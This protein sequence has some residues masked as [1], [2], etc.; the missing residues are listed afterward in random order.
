MNI[1]NLVKYS[2]EANQLLIT[3]RSGW[4]FIGK[5]R[6]ETVAYHSFYTAVLAHW[7]SLEE[8]KQYPHIDPH[9]TLLIPL[10]HDLHEVRTGDPNS[11]Y[12]TYFPRHK[13]SEARASRDQI[14]RTEPDTKVKLLRYHFDFESH[15]TLAGKIAK[16]ADWLQ[17]IFMAK[18]FLDEDFPLAQRWIDGTREKLR[19]KTAQDIAAKI[20]NTDNV[21]LETI[22]PRLNA[23]ECF[24]TGVLAFVLTDP[25]TN[26]PEES[27][28]CA[29]IPFIRLVA[30]ITALSI[31]LKPPIDNDYHFSETALITA[32]NANNLQFIIRAAK[33]DKDITLTRRQ[34]EYIASQIK[35]EP[36]R[37][38][39]ARFMSPEIKKVVWWE[40]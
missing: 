39:A 17:M 7:I 19:T 31:G 32:A 27:A 37:E 34:L 28:F 5:D 20:I 38:L 29:L 26:D 22:W 9:R 11:V 3:Y 16:D 25:K 4:D 10:F 36:A 33:K 23:H 8:R 12:K 40:Q 18:K 30:E 35:T 14:R 15:S 1:D 13:E 21:D 6:A 2:L 24:L